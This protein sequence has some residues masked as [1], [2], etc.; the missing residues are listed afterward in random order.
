ML[1]QAK[2]V[3]YRD[4]AAEAEELVQHLTQQVVGRGAEG[5]KDK[6]DVLLQARQDHEQ[7][8]ELRRRAEEAEQGLSTVQVWWTVRGVFW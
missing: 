7:I 6:V 3:S 1:L 8:K 4:E 5:R 2:L